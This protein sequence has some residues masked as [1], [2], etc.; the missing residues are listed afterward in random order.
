MKVGA[1]DA[2]VNR[3]RFPGTVEG[4]LPEARP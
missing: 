2:R 3:G 4:I 1:P